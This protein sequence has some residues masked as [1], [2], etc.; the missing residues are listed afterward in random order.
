MF[1]DSIYSL[2]LSHSPFPF[3]LP[4]PHSLVG[5]VT[6]KYADLVAGPSNPLNSDT[7]LHW[8]I[9]PSPSSTLVKDTFAE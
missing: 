5:V 4:L 8:Y 9:P 1:L 2:Y 6:L 7:T 3:S